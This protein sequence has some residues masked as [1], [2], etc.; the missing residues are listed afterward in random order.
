MPELAP[1]P[2]SP[3]PSIPHPPIP[4][5][6]PLP[7]WPTHHDP[8]KKRWL[9]AA[10]LLTLL[11]L[12]AYALSCFYSAANPGV[13]Q[14]GYLMTARRPRRSTHPPLRPRRPLSIRLPH[15]HHDRTLSTPPP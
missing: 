10:L 2:P 6:S 14:S 7:P 12:F 5:L 4:Q 9:A 3:I 15:V 1:H 11:A 8:S 13:D